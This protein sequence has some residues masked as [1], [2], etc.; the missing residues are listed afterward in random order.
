MISKVLL[1]KFR[2]GTCTP[3]ELATLKAY[4][5][6]EDVTALENLLEADWEELDSVQ[7]SPTAVEQRI[8][9]RLETS[10]QAERTPV[11]RR[12]QPTWKAWRNVAAAILILLTA[13]SGYWIL[14]KW[15]SPATL[16]VEN[17]TSTPMQ[18][19]LEDSSI[20]WLSER[21]T[22]QYKK[23]F[24]K[25]KRNIYLQGEAFFEVAKDKNRPFTVYAKG[26]GTTAL[27][28]SFNIQ[29]FTDSSDVK[30]ALVTGKVSVSPLRDGKPQTQQER[31]LT[32]GKQL[33]YNLKNKTIRVE[34][35]DS[36]LTLAWREGKLVFD[37]ESLA[38]VLSRLSKQY[39]VTIQF[40]ERVE[41]CVLNTSFDKNENLENILTILTFSNNLEFSQRNGKYIIVG[42]GCE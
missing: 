24:P 10:T 30:V 21:S 15:N 36:T 32:P 3:E 34:D 14:Q 9:Q 40:D 22:I 39:Q 42:K 7:A 27:G 17:I 12:L 33:R 8:W 26:F 13:A 25:H 11:I 29:A 41:K 16:I 2:S 23:P 19:T 6:Q 1:E 18:I 28:T 4:F 20:I 37:N 5:E 38:I 31:I 35:F